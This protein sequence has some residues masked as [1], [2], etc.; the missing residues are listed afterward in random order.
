MGTRSTLESGKLGE[1]MKFLI[2]LGILCVLC[3]DIGQVE[4]IHFKDCPPDCAEVPCAKNPCNVLADPCPDNT[5]IN[6]TGNTMK[7][8]VLLGILCVFYISQVKGEP[9][10]RC[11]SE[12]CQGGPE[13][14]CP[15]PEDGSNVK[16]PCR[17]KACARE[18]VC[19]LCHC[20]GECRAFCEPR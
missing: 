2:V 19:R 5:S 8:F 20:D 11:P 15:D 1:N 12:K 7:L 13:V 18:D 3:L 16:N 6:L 10:R 4:S 14:Q 9:A 17:Y